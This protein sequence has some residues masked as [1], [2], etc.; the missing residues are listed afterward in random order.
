MMNRSAQSVQKAVLEVLQQGLHI[1]RDEQLSHGEVPNYQHMEDESWQYSFSPAISAYI[2]DELSCFDPLS[3]QF[4]PQT[5]EWSEWSGRIPFLKSVAQ[6]RQSIRRFLAWQESSTGGWR[7]FGQGSGLPAD[8]DLT[9][10]A[11]TAFVDP[12]N[13]ALSA[14][15][16]RRIADLEWFRTAEG[17]F[18]SS[19]SRQE[20]APNAMLHWMANCN[21]LRFL[22]LSGGEAELLQTLI[23]N[24]LCSGGQFL[25]DALPLHHAA[26]KAWRCGRL[27]SIA[28]LTS[29]LL[30]LAL[31]QRNSTG[32]LSAALAVLVLLDLDAPEEEIGRSMSQL[33]DWWDSPVSRKFET[34]CG[35]DCGSPALTAAFAMAAAA[36]SAGIL[37]RHNDA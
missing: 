16:D 3:I 18:Q 29:S 26:A 9:A 33:L 23:L 5:I 35:S 10:C 15:V 2:Y 1:I 34:Y 7:F 19:G 14:A 6:V 31:Q 20:T 22:A 25:D 11:A 17:T 36:R 24:A 8:L 4:E 21:V 27:G 12:G 28:T 37:G 13:S 32:P 30:P